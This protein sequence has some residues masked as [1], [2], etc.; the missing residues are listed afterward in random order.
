MQGGVF[1][2]IVA[3]AKEL[4]YTEPDPRDDLNGMDIARK[5]LI[6]ARE[7]GYSLELGDVKVS[8]LLPELYYQA[9]S[10]DEFMT[11]LKQL[12]AE[13]TSKRNAAQSENKALR[14]I[15]RFEQGRASVSL[16]TVGPE[17]PAFG[18]R[19]TDSMLLLYTETYG[20]RPMVLSGPGAGPEITARG[21]LADIIAINKTY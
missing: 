17:H 16:E 9:G 14:Y 18:M 7:A 13:F 10:V 12:D 4:G 2:E 3:K 15:A 8:R 5:I 19:D 11:S 21:V 6:L 1:S 20:E